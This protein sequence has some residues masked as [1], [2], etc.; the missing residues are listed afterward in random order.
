MP[1]VSY[2]T[3]RSGIAQC[4]AFTKILRRQCWLHFNEANE[5]SFYCSPLLERSLPH[6][7]SAFLFREIPLKTAAI[8][9]MPA[10]NYHGEACYNVP[11]VAT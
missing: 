8:W 9:I 5:T 6:T 10:S 4:S 1:H 11:S 3:L 7:P 2:N